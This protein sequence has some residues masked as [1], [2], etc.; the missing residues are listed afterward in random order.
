MNRRVGKTVKLGNLVADRPG[1]IE[2]VSAVFVFLAAFFAVTTSFGGGTM[3]LA[4]A[5]AVAAVVVVVYVV[6]YGGLR[7]VRSCV[8]P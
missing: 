1:I 3:G 2:S 6:F 5:G 4:S 8:C 7:A